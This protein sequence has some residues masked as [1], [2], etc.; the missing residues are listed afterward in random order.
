VGSGDWRPL[1]C[2][3]TSY[4]SAGFGTILQVS[5]IASHWLENCAM[6]NYTPHGNDKKTANIIKPMQTRIY[7]KKYI[8]NSV[9]SEG[10]T[11]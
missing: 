5:T 3:L 9:N 4:W 11:K 2:F 7:R 10:H 1:H 6:H 8:N